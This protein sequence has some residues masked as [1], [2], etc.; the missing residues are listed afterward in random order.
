MFQRFQKEM[1]AFIV[2]AIEL[3]Y[4][5]RGALQYP[6]AFEL[7]PTEREQWNTWLKQR[8]E[9]EAARPYPCY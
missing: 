1:K 4:W 7:T 6:D 9:V 2:E 5:S 3:S 8:L